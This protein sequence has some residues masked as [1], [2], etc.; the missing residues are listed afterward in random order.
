MKWLAKPDNGPRAY[1]TRKRI[2]F[3]LL[4]HIC[5]DGQWHWLEKVRVEQFFGP[6][7]GWWV[8]SKYIPL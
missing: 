3:I 2:V 8:T 7:S 4:P 5:T 6:L 1:D